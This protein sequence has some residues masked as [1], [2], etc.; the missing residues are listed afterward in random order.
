MAKVSRHA[1]ELKKLRESS[2]GEIEQKVKKLYEEVRKEAKTKTRETETDKPHTLIKPK[3]ESR[4]KKKRRAKARGEKVQEG[5]TTTL[6][7][8]AF[9][10]EITSKELRRMLRKGGFKK[11]SGRWEWP[12][13]GKEIKRIKK[14]LTP[15]SKRSDDENE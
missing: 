8:L 10:F 13:N 4:E 1:Y 3:S 11:P 5:P 15:P 2:T 12:T 6:K 9:D 14:I 7:E